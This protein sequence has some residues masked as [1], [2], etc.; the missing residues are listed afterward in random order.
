MSSVELNIIERGLKGQEW[1]AE[2]GPITAG[3]LAKISEQRTNNSSALNALPTPFARFFVVKEAFRRVLEEIKDSHKSA[4]DAYNRLVSDTLDI[5]EL[6]YNQTYHEKRWDSNSRKIAVLEW[7]YTSHLKELKVQVPIL[8]SAVENY[9]NS[10]LKAA[11]NKLFFVVLIDEGRDYLLGTSSPFT[12]FVTP[13]DLD[14]RLDK[15]GDSTNSFMGVRYQQMPSLLRKSGGTYFRDIRMFKER[16][17]DFKNFM[18]YLVDNSPIGDEMNELRDYIK[19]VQI[20]DPDI[21]KNWQPQFK[22]IMSD[23]SNEVVVNGLPISKDTG[24]ST[25]NFF[26]DTLIRLP[27]RLAKD[28]YQSMIYA[29][30]D[31]NREYDYLLPVSR[32]GLELMDGSF[33]CVCKDAR[34]KVIISLKYKGQ[35]YIKE[36]FPD[37]SIGSRGRI[38][39]LYKENVNFNLGVFPSILSPNVAENK[40]FK[41]M[42]VMSDSTTD[43]KPVSV[44][45]LELS[46]FFR[47]AD[48]RFEEIETIDPDNSNAKY[49][50][51]PA[52]VRSKQDCSCEVEA[53]SK[54]YEV[55]NTQF[56]AI[57]LR[58]VLHSGTC[59]GVLIPNWKRAQ[60]TNDAFTYAVDLGTTNTY[61]SC[62]HLSKDN[63]PEQL[64]M[65]EPMVAF[66]HDFKRSNQ[67]SLISL[68]ENALVPTCRKNFTTEFVP[69]LIDGETY[70]FP[71]RTALCVKTGDHSKPSL[72]DN[73]NIAFFY[74][75]TLGLGNQS[76]LTDIKWEDSHE[77]ELRLFIRELLLIIK[78]DILQKNG[79]LANTKLIWFRPLSFKGNIKDLYTKIWEEEAKYILNVGSS[80]IECIS[81]SEAPYYY[82]NTKNSFN[83]VDAVSIVDIGGGSSDFIYFADGKPQIANSVHFGCDVLWSNGFSGFANDRTNGIYERFADTIHLGNHDDELEILNIRMRADKEI[84]T[85][86]IINF[87][88]SND[89][90]CE[91]SKKLKENYKP[92]FLYHFASIVYFMANMYKVKKLACPRSVLF[93]GNGSKYI[94][95]LLS[96]DKST[97]K[98]L[99][100]TIFK[101]VY[102]DI[103]NVQVI[104]P[105]SR[106]ECTCY[107]GLY[108]DSDVAVPEE[109]NFQGISSKEYENVEQLKADYPDISG[110]LLKS[111]SQFNK[112]Y[113]KLLRILIGKGELDNKVDTDSIVNTI[114]TGIQDSLDKNFKTQILQKMGD[115]EV[116]HDSIFFLPIIDN[117]L[118]LTHI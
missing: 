57:N 46:F 21:N 114:S 115:S 50:V 58:F 34:T 101:E 118:K 94:D 20:S 15:R 60:R 4:G 103:K 80:Q 89:K 113:D 77:K 44:E 71:I 18:F 26:N 67:H 99:V 42:A 54:F 33:E 28:Y 66:L 88:L 92:L 84:S 59:E 86:D 14:K 43:F 29:N 72:F 25:V 107:G 102:G 45:Q 109:F 76:I 7:D 81:E 40:Y 95:G 12:G 87:W 108:R 48:L 47:N 85:K 91:I 31:D 63:E 62:R 27:F 51:R 8:G 55:F 75:K 9:F 30:A 64:N 19:Q 65:K 117:V 74:E 22:T 111:L 3:D 53:G 83:S 6:L 39:N 69:A 56:D 49:G 41:V 98:E 17:K 96:S 100:T 35:E 68:I 38:V 10:D 11:K 36:Y 2:K 13:P 1:T 78:T 16:D 82:F 5:F 24:I 79:L 73:C 116:Y 37:E 93:C 52:V 105:E 61:I 106:K 23:L 110:E 112:L 97:I 104:L 32:E 70:R 90:R